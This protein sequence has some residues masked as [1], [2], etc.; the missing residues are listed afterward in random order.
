ME[1]TGTIKLIFEE[2]GITAKFRKRELVLTTDDQY[3]QVILVEFTQ[4]RIE[5][6]NGLSVGQQIAVSIN[7]RG[8]EWNSPSGEIKYFSSIE[9]WRV[10]ATGAGG[11]GGHQAPR[12]GGTGG[13][14][15]GFAGPSDGSDDDIPF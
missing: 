4:D 11:G 10:S 1:L 5:L 12:G 9:G 6:V 15:G 7:I 2:K 13:R 14:V 3:P 8:R